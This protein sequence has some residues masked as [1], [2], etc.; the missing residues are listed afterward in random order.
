MLALFD[1]DYLCYNVAFAAE[2]AEKYK[3]QE[4]G[5]EPHPPS[6]ETVSSMLEQRI[7]HCMH[8]TEATDAK[9]YLSSK[10]NFRDK[11]STTGYKLDR[12][13][14]PSQYANLRAVILGLYGGIIEEGLEADDC[15]AIQASLN[16]DDSIII[17]P[18]KDL[19]QVPCWHYRYETGRISSLGP[20][21]AENYGHFEYEGSKYFGYG[22][23]M[24]LAQCLMGD[25][26]DSIVALAGVGPAKAFKLLSPTQTYEEGLEAVVEAYKGFYG[27]EWESKLTENAQLLWM[28]RRLNEDGSPVLWGM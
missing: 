25:P 20:F 21:K 4:Q 14:K 1:A 5:R 19:W 6:W 11:I 22:D 2:A 24:F 9:F 17:G 16:P 10:T 27:D 23:R 8:E 12:G 26:V 13:E 3:A 28:T 18:D 7:E 15:M